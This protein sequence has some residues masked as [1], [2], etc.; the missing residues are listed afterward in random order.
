MQTQAFEKHFCC[1]ESLVWHLRV[2]PG[3]NYLT[4]TKRQHSR[5]LR[6]FYMRKKIVFLLLS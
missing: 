1:S 5:N 6:L 2:L 3:I 4:L